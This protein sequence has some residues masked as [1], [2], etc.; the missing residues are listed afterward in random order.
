MAR[1]LS[2]SMS[3]AE[4]SALAL[5]GHRWPAAGCLLSGVNRTSLINDLTCQK[6]SN[7][8]LHDRTGKSQIRTLNR[9]YYSPQ[10][11]SDGCKRLRFQSPT[12][13]RRFMHNRPSGDPIPP[14]ADVEMTRQLKDRSAARRYLNAPFL[15]SSRHFSISALR[16]VP[17]CSGEPPT[18][19]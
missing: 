16:K 2:A 10:I 12:A 11:A 4:M 5:N 7:G 8:K 1:T 14:R 13:A 18:K 19:R 15:W 17:S 9:P 3:C 6:C